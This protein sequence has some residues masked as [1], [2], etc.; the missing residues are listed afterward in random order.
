M[1]IAELEVRMRTWLQTD[2]KA[3]RFFSSELP[4]GY[5]LFRSSPD[6]LYLRQLFIAQDQ[7]R[8]GFGR[9]CFQILRREIWPNDVR[10]TVEV[11]SRN[12]PAVDF[13][14]AVGYIDYSITLEIMPGAK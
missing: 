13:W 12:T 5:A 9:E 14:R 2:Y 6:E 3:V 1:T 7:R 8:R 11:L 10:L 4:I